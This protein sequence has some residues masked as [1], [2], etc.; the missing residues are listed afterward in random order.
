MCMAQMSK[1]MPSTSKDLPLLEHT[2]RPWHALE[3]V[4]MQVQAHAVSSMLESYAP[5]PQAEK[6]MSMPS[7][8]GG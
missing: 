5:A 7:K 4:F 2:C 1:R 8:V 3:S 6:T